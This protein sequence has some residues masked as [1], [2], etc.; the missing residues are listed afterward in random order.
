[1]KT[2]PASATLSRCAAG[3]R[4]SGPA[5]GPRSLSSPA[6]SASG[7]ALGRSS[8]PPDVL[9]SLASPGRRSGAARAAT[10]VAV[11]QTSILRPPRVKRTMRPPLP[12]R[13]RAQRGN[14][15]LPTRGGSSARV[16]APR[17]GSRGRSRT[18]RSRSRCR[19]PRVAATARPARSPSAVRARI[20]RRSP[21]ICTVTS[22][23]ASHVAEPQ[24]VLRA[25][26]L[27]GHHDDVGRRRAGR[28]AGWCAAC[29]YDGRGAP[30]GR[31]GPG[32]SSP[33]RLARSRRCGPG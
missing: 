29:R 26:G 28:R 11:A 19:A 25:T 31:S 22:G 32:P 5:S 21:R 30:A 7:E 14:R 27:R 1:M 24:R 4:R 6:S 13:D 3:A 20:G 18:G 12:N 10:G 23:S 15:E 2:P 16:R 9:S 33:H 17:R 8:G